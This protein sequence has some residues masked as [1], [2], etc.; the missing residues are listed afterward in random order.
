MGTMG[1][2]GRG[3]FR[4]WLD[5]SLFEGP[6]TMQA[7]IWQEDLNGVAKFITACLH[8]MNPSNEGQTSWCGWKRCNLNL[9]PIGLTIF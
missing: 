7:F 5:R 9:D 4:H 2:V 8:K 3:A 6:Q 1:T